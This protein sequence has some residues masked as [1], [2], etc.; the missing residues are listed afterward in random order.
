MDI[1]KKLKTTLRIMI[2]WSVLAVIS[3][4]AM[5]LAL[6]MLSGLARWLLAAP[7]IA[8]LVVSF[9]GLPIGWTMSYAGTLEKAR[10]VNAINSGVLSV[11]DICAMTGHKPK[12][13]LPIIQSLLGKKYLTGYKFNAEKTAL[14]QIEIINKRVKKCPNCGGVITREDGIC[15]YCSLRN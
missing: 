11:T 2:I 13:L 8:V 10:V 1:E 9:Y 4:P 12:A 15:E 3:I 7:C 5:I 6:T 14:E